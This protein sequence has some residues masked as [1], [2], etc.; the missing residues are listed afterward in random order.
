MKVNVRDEILQKTHPDKVAEE[1]R[2]QDHYMP[3]EV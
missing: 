2:K 3:F 1:N